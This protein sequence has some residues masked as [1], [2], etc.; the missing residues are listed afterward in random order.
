MQENQ[1]WLGLWA[2]RPSN[3]NNAT[4]GKTDQQHAEYVRSNK[5]EVGRQYD[6]DG[7]NS[8]R[9][10]RLDDAEHIYHMHQ[11]WQR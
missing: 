11:E 1:Q 8:G 7:T 4:T 5:G 10:V 2:G 3:S 6:N 9:C